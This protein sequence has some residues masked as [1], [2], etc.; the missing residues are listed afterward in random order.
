MS[1]VM[2]VIHLTELTRSKLHM[3]VSQQVSLCVLNT[4]FLLVQ[5]FGRPN[6]ASLDPV[7]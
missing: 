4:L 2:Q 6:F 7:R 5:P 3:V 1:Q